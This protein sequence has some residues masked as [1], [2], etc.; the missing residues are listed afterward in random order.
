M[1][2]IKKIKLRD[3]LFLDIETVPVKEN[4]DEL[5]DILKKHWNKK[6]LNIKNEKELPPEELFFEKAAIYSEFAKIIC[7]GVGFV[8]E[9]PGGDREMRLKTFYGHDEKKILE[10]FRELL[11][12]RYND[13]EKEKYLCAHN[14]KEFDFP[15]IARRMIVNGIEIPPILDVQ[16]KKPW[17]TTFL[18]T[19][20]M[21]K[22]GD[23]KSFVSLELLAELLGVPTP[24]DD[25]DG[26]QVAKVYYK[27]NDL[28]RIVTYCQKD[29]ATTINIFL[30]YRREDIIPNDKIKIV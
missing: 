27:E 18:D 9:L 10:E 12:N 20:E 19:M 5:S 17:E 3:I 30:R 28:E 22:F 15:F 7:I 25:I 23:Y 21:W 29:V 6:A 11:I 2:D 14:G 16:G 13:K 24:K 1:D 8:N 26:S 4:Y